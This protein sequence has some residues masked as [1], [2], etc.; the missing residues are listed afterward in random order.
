MKHVAVYMRVSSDT[1]SHDSQEAELRK[2]LIGLGLDPD[3]RSQV[4]WY[5][6]TIS[7]DQISR[8]ALDQLRIRAQQG[9]VSK[10]VCWKI[11][12]LGRNVLAGINLVCGWLDH[13]IGV[14]SVTQQ[15]D[16]S[17]PIGKAVAALLFAL[18]EAELQNIRDRIKAGIEKARANGKKWGGN[19]YSSTKRLRGKVQMMK[20]MYLRGVPVTEIATVCKVHRTYVYRLAKEKKWNL[21]VR[22]EARQIE[23]ARCKAGGTS[24]PAR[25]NEIINFVA[26]AI[27]K[28]ETD[29]EPS[30]S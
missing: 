29:N 7:G 15:F 6:D 17:G 9:A 24:N 14:V 1:Q 13:D 20:S 19:R 4:V 25:T 8:K 18:A 22:E 10:V 21:A 2:Y 11:D 5:V 27:L 23:K 12:R 26:D 30:D 16:F 3:D 28:P